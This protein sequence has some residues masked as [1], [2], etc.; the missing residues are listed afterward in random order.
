MASSRGRCRPRSPLP[1][2]RGRRAPRR[3]GAAQLIPRD[4]LG[5]KQSAQPRGARR[6]SNDAPAVQVAAARTWPRHDL[7][8]PPARPST[9]S[10][11][12]PAT[13]RAAQPW[14]AATPASMAHPHERARFWTWGR[15]PCRSGGTAGAGGP[16]P[17]RRSDTSSRAIR[18]LLAGGRGLTGG[19]ARGEQ[20][21]D[22]RAPTG[23]QAAGSARRAPRRRCCRLGLE[24]AEGCGRIWLCA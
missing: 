1:P 23:W 3:R 9:T 6:G 14:S 15:R 7:R 13:P 24:C 18:S 20:A 2:A 17:R 16:S 5:A 8:A 11:C 22:V 21:I 19:Q 4:L 10:G 12:G